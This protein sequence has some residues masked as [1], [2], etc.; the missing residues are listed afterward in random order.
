M[1]F[2][3]FLNT[4]RRPMY[5]LFFPGEIFNIHARAHIFIFRFYNLYGTFHF[6][7]TFTEADLITNSNSSSSS[8]TQSRVALGTS[9]TNLEHSGKC[10]SGCKEYHSEF[11]RVTIAINSVQIIIPEK[12]EL[13]AVTATRIYYYTH[14][15]PLGLIN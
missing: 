4:R 14:A 1:S 10:F 11:R 2:V 15:F 9:K 13:F 5:L 3:L 12:C 7:Y 6:A 8:S